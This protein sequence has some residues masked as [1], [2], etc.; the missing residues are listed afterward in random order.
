M[1][2][3]CNLGKHRNILGDLSNYWDS[4]QEPVEKQKDKH[5]RKGF[6]VTW[7]MHIHLVCI[8]LLW[9]YY[10]LVTDSYP[11]TFILQ[12]CFTGIR[13]IIRSWVHRLSFLRQTS[14]NEY[15]FYSFLVLI[16]LS[17]IN[18][19]MRFMC[20]YSSVLLSWHNVKHLNALVS[21]KLLCRR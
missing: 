12:V 8:V 18:S 7:N 15:S 20:L 17:V 11:L 10:K 4:N 2:I 5:I 13:A 9:L 19:F 3:L 14:W 6:D 16:I 1:W 21:M